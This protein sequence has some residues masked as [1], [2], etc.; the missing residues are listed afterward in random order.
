MDIKVPDLKV[1][2]VRL[3][4]FSKG[5]SPCHLPRMHCICTLIVQ[6]TRLSS[7]RRR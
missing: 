2:D 6:I 4:M 1:N 7:G 3:K 5:K